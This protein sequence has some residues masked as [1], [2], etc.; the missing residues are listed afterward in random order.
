MMYAVDRMMLQFTKL[1]TAL[2]ESQLHYQTWLK[3]G[4]V[5]TK[6]KALI[7]YD[8]IMCETEEDKNV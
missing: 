4:N 1:A 2:K 8:R 6:T 7:I 3:T 5:A